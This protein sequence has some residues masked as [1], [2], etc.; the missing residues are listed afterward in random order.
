MIVLSYMQIQLP[1]KPRLMKQLETQNW[2]NKYITQLREA[3]KHD[4]LA[5]AYQEEAR[6]TIVINKLKLNQ[7]KTEVV[8]INPRCRSRPPLDSLQIGNVTVVP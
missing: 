2:I 8:L 4:Q 6:Q 7:D 1:R 5:S 3:R